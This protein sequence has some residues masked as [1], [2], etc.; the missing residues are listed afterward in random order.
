MYMY[1]SSYE[2]I[3]L[4]PCIDFAP[5]NPVT[6]SN[7]GNQAYLCNTLHC[8]SH[9]II[10]SQSLKKKF[11]QNKYKTNTRTDKTLHWLKSTCKKLVVM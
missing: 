2:I 7:E 1:L 11:L 10:G 4:T 5:A 6:M 3:I 8:L 9:S